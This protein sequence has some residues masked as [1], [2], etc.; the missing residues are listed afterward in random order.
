MTH[1]ENDST[2]FV[3]HWGNKRRLLVAG[4]DQPGHT[5]YLRG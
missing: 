3:R 2:V 5:R 1:V 4:A